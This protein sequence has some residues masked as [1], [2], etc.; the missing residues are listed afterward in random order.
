MSSAN[1]K[2]YFESPGN[3][4]GYYYRVYLI[5]RAIVDPCGKPGHVCVSSEVIL[6][7]HNKRSFHG[8]DYFV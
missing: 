4:P 8:S 5:V 1:V 3:T 7:C 2:H 6:I